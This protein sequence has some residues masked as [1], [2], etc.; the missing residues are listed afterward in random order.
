MY[1][2]VLV[3][4]L[5]IGLLACRSNDSVVSAWEVNDVYR[6]TMVTPNSTSGAKTFQGPAINTMDAANTYEMFS[7][8]S[9]QSKDGVKSYEL[10]VMLT[11]FSALRNYDSAS[12][13]NMPSTTFK[14]V[15]KESGACED[16]GCMFKEL[17]S[18]R[19]S[20]EFLKDR[21]KKGFQISISSKAG[22]KTDLFVPAQYIQGYLKAVDG[23]SY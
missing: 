5:S 2:I 11:Y 23:T 16:R 17:L 4:A 19:L 14:V 15:S 21:T 9:E 3:V 13:E 18:I 1:R 6:S 20:D 10:M 8:R 12:L 7:L 22:A